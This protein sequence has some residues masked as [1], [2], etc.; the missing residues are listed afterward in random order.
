MY[1]LLGSN[2]TVMISVLLG[3]GMHSV[4]C[5]L[6]YNYTL[7]SYTQPAVV[8]MTLSYIMMTTATSGGYWPINGYIDA[9]RDML[10]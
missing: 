1:L 10:L 9:C 4:E 5:R 6:V 2:N 3:G 8:I 7:V